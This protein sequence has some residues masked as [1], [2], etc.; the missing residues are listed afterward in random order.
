MST[1]LVVGYGSIGERHC[2]I[3][4][5]LGF[6]TAIISRR[7]IE[8]KRCFNSIKDALKYIQAD[9]IVIANETS[10]H[11]NSLKE[12]DT[13]GFKGNVL[14]EK[15]IFSS[16][17]KLELKNIANACVA[18]NLRFHPIMQTLRD[19][20]QDQKIISAQIYCGQY[21]PDWRPD[22]DYRK[23]YS[24]DLNKGG[25]VLR[26]LSHELDYILWLFGQCKRLSAIGGKKS[27]LEIS[28]DD[29]WSI[30]MELEQCP[31]LSLQLNYL[32]RPGQRKIVV[33]TRNHTFCA[34][35]MNATFSCDGKISPFNI[36]R[37]DTYI[38]QHQDFLA[39]RYD[40]LCSFSQGN[41]VLHLMEMIEKA[42]KTSSWVTQ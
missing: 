17:Q 13:L 11:L 15:P 5:Q 22:T 10:E 37:N 31:M 30:L 29:S 41:N 42:N 14:I 2:D 35:L 25:G 34:D 12:I 18:Y 1:A 33:N 40:I 4:E 26:D 6:S 9:Y 36:E 32:D 28:S 39:N 27:S 21:L 24:A 7:N 23:S 38:K 16:S 8:N 3:L 19:A 20:L